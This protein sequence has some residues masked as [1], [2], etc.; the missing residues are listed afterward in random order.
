MSLLEVTVAVESAQKLLE[1]HI[2]PTSELADWCYESVVLGKDELDPA[3]VLD[4]N[5]LPEEVLT[6]QYL[7][8]DPNTEKDYLVYFLTSIDCQRV[9]AQGIVVNR[10]LVWSEGNQ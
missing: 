2:G 1:T 5:L 9:L 8:I 6:H 3:M 7:W 4:K 10:K